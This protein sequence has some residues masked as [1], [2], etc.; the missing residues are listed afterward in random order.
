MGYIITR[1]RNDK[2]A[3]LSIQDRARLIGHF[4]ASVISVLKI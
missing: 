2:M 3:K 1:V 4:V